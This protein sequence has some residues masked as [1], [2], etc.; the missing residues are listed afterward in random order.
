MAKIGQNLEGVKALGNLTPIPKGI[1]MAHVVETDLLDEGTEKERISLKWAVLDEGEF[2][3]RLV[4]D[5]IMLAGSDKSVNY[6]RQKLKLI[7]ETI[8]HSNPN[9][10]DDSDELLQLPC[11]IEVGFGKDEYKDKNEIKAYKALDTSFPAEEPAQATPPPPQAAPP[12][13]KAP[14]RPATPAA[15]PTRQAP[16]AG[17]KQATPPPPRQAP[18]KSAPPAQTEDGSSYFEG[19]EVV[20]EEVA[21]S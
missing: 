19:A 16:P 5:N 15:P 20:G 17:T 4:W 21:P 6:G 10:I 18:P 14:A 11:C 7:A 9:F 13:A 12:A 8:G 3:G 2:Y 1:Y